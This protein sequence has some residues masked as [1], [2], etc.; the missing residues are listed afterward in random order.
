MGVVVTTVVIRANSQLPTPKSWG[1]LTIKAPA[2]AKVEMLGVA[3]T[4][5]TS[6]KK[7]TL[8]L[9]TPDLGPD[10]APSQHAFVF[11]ISGAQVLPG[12]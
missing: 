10:Q 4:L 5:K 12:K 9:N 2:N 1:A 3:G 6:M 11:K 7:D 8:K